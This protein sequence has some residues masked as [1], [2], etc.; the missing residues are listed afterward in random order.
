MEQHVLDSI[1][2]G[3]QA[4]LGRLPLP[5][6]CR[7]GPPALRAEYAAVLVDARYRGLLSEPRQRAAAA[8]AH[9]RALAPDSPGSPGPRG[10]WVGA[11]AVSAAS[12]ECGAAEVEWGAEGRG[13][14]E[15]DVWGDEDDG[16][17]ADAAAAEEGWDGEEEAWEEE[18]EDW[19]DVM[20]AAEA[21]ELLRDDVDVDGDGAPSTRRGEECIRDVG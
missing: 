2:E 21:S 9:R 20:A 19:E 10:S 18:E 11:S 15:I 13:E 7:H 14:A 5:F 12:D 3:A 1:E 17:D 16:W 4:S 6:S 8:A